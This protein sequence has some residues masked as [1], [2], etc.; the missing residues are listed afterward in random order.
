M[1]RTHIHWTLVA[2]IVG[3]AALAVV[4]LAPAPVAG[5]VVSRTLTRLEE[6]VILYGQNVPLL[7]ERPSRELFVYTFRE[8]ALKEIPSQVDHMSAEMVYTSTVGLPLAITDQ[9]VFMAADL[10]DR[11]AAD[12]VGA[13]LAISPYW[14]EIEVTDPLSP[15][16]KGW[17]YVIHSETLTHTAALPY[18]ALDVGTERIQTPVYVL[19]FADNH[20]G[21]DYLALSGS[22]VDILDRTKIR[23]DTLL[24]PVNEE[25]IGPQP[26]DLI[27]NGPVR[28][29]AR[30]GAVIAYRSLLHMVIKEPL[31]SVVT[32]AR[33]S[34]DF[35]SAATPGMFYNANTPGGVPV[36][37]VPDTVAATPVSPWWQ[38]SCATG[39]VVQVVDDAS[40][41]GGTQ[42]NYYRDNSAPD[43]GDAGDNRS[44]CDVGIAAAN[45]MAHIALLSA[46]VFLPVAPANAGAQVAL[47]V[48]NPLQ[49]SAKEQTLT[50]V[51]SIPLVLR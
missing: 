15:T 23:L 13:A 50:K 19:G 30:Q 20:P 39:N 7:L 27:K 34:T 28:V 48:A 2:A 36:D 42:T 37:G 1:N 3:V 18:V 44:Y 31:P 49:V 25:N 22:G 33:V 46:Y 51:V 14:Y 4:A 6:P 40:D 11:A 41:V 38:L 26:L 16:L 17:A 21:F 24:G 35:S 29:I 9:I 12:D 45:P 47:Y 43:L 5:G 32:A 8:G 10:G